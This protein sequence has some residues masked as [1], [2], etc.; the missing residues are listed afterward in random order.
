MAADSG[1]ILVIMKKKQIM[2]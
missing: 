2:F 1:E